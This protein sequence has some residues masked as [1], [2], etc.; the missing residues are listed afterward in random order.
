MFHRLYWA[1]NR[2]CNS[3]CLRRSQHLLG[4]ISCWSLS[5]YSL[6]D[7]KMWANTL[8]VNRNVA[9]YREWKTFSVKST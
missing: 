4:G 7:I 6:L 9:S 1:I 5:V 2:F 8:G 3:L